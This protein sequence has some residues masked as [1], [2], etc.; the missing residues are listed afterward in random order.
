MRRAGRVR[1]PR[2]APAAVP[3]VV[4]L[5]GLG[6]FG[7]L[8]A[9][10]DGGLRGGD[11]AGPPIG[12]H[13]DGPRRGEEGLAPA[14]TGPR[15]HPGTWEI[16]PG[17]YDDDRE[18]PGGPI[19][20]ALLPSGKVLL[21]TYNDTWLFDPRTRVFEGPI[22]SPA[23]VNCAGMAMLADGRLFVAGGWDGFD[24][25]HRYK[26]L[27]A[28]QAFDPVAERW[29]ALP[30]MQD[31]RWYP[32]AVTLADGRVAV[33]TGVDAGHT[34][35][36]VEVW[37]PAR[38]AWSVGAGERLLPL[39]ARAH[40]LP[41]GTVLFT[42]PMTTTV[43]WDPATERFRDGPERSGGTRRGGASVLV[44]AAEGL[45]M[46]FGGFGGNR[47]AERY[48]AAAQRWVPA[49]DL[50]RPRVWAP[51]VVLPT[52]DVL[53]VGGERNISEGSQPAEVWEAR[54]GAWVEVAEPRY[55]R[56]YHSTAQLLPDGSVMATGAQPN[57]EVYRPWYFFQ[58]RPVLAG[59]PD[60]VPRGV[61]FEVASPDAASLAR[62]VLLRVGGDTH[63]LNTDQRLVPLA[64]AAPE[65]AGVR[66]ATVPANPA[67]APPGM[68]LLF[69]LDAEG[70]PS[71]GRFVRVA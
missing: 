60:V 24:E 8:M 69:V 33:F 44:D 63:N 61:P 17:V 59:A 1:P 28:A 65:K 26:G 7:A 12:P 2:S 52:G 32:T 13:G 25:Q 53:A 55:T 41:D 4:L 29:V 67:V 48:D 30:P 19:H 15:W 18:P 9:A 64:L 56:V 42:G 27:P 70:R 35:R 40:L 57:L 6:A 5:L 47:S 46:T 39:Y 22:A 36:R 20:S 31:V 37:D 58:P 38:G 66:A 45:V 10:P 50:V 21:F 3:A 23:V 54:T 62:A 34:T 14:T 51:G 16:V 71:E 11:G 43:V 68:Y 49:G